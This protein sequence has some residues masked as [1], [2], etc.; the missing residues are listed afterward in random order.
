VARQVAARQVVAQEGD[1]VAYVSNKTN[2]SLTFIFL[3]EFGCFRNAS[4]DSEENNDVA[5][6]QNR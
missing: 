4:K 6:S 1:G 5:R 3:E 2:L